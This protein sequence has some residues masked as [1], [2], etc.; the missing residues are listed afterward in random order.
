MPTIDEREI[1]GPGTGAHPE[2]GRILVP[3]D[4]RPGA[5]TGR[6]LPAA[7]GGGAA[8]RH[9]RRCP[10]PGPRADPRDW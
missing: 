8:L 3:P 6:V 2:D 1:T 9:H 4:P 7:G 5:R 10:V